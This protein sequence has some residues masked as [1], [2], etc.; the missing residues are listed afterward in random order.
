M[1]AHPT[2]VALFFFLTFSADYR[3]RGKSIRYRERWGRSQPGR[4]WSQSARVGGKV[5]GW[6]AASARCHSRAART[7][8][9]SRWRKRIR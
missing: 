4:Q 3:K 2:V 9:R 1:S 5:G 6:K 8:R 7:K